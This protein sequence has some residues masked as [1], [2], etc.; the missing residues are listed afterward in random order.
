MLKPLI[1]W[2][3]KIC[4]KFLK[5]LEYQTVLLVSWETCMWVKKQHLEPDIEQLTGSKLGKKYD[6]AVYC[7]PAY[8]TCMQSTLCKMPGWNQDCQE[9]YQQP[10]I[11]RWYPSNGRKW[12]GTK[13]PHDE[14]EKEWKPGLKFIIQKTKIMASSPIISWQIEGK[15]W[16]Q[17]QILFW[18]V[19]NHCGRW[20]QPWN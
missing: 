17:W 15:K 1:V 3:I 14:S 19:Q 18:G 8:L 16:K 4:G 20:L 11:C 10:Q 7:H 9:K 6:K 5:R 12:R 13:E 2:I